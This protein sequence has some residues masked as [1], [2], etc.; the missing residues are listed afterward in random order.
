MSARPLPE[1]LEHAFP[2]RFELL[3][4]HRGGESSTLQVRDRS[5][6]GAVRA[7][8]ILPTGEPTGEVGA[9]IAVRHPAVAAVL[10]VGTLRNG[11]SFVLREWV[12]G[13]TPRVLPGDPEALKALL[14]ELLEVLAFVH[15]RG[16]LHLDLKPANLILRPGTASSPFRLAV[17][18][19]GLAVRRGEDSRGGTPFYAAP[20]VLLGARPDERADLFAVGAIAAQALLAP[21]RLDLARFVAAFPGQPFERAAGF[22]LAALPPPFGDF[23]A[24]CVAR[25]PEQRFPDAQSALE[26]LLGHGGR[27]SRA[28]LHLDPVTACGT[29]LPAFTD[30][31]GDLVLTGGSPRQ[32][33]GLGLH[34]A[35]ALGDVRA[36]VEHADQFVLHRKPG[37]PAT[38]W[39]VPPPDAS[40]LA[41]HLGR[42]CGLRD[43]AAAQA[44]AWLQ[45]QA[46]A[47]SVDVDAILDELAARGDLVPSGV[48]FAWPD[49]AAGRLG[50]QRTTSAPPE[51][52]A[53]IRDLAAGGRPREAI[54]AFQALAARADPR[55]PAAREALALG[56]LDAGEPALALPF[57]V[58]LDP[59]RAQALLETGNLHA[60]A[61]LVQSCR[62]PGR[63]ASRLARVAAQLHAAAGRFDAALAL[64][65]DDGDWR[66]QATRAAILELAGRHEACEALLTELLGRLPAGQPFAAG[67]LHTLAGHL[68]RRRGDL[69]VAQREFEAALACFQAIG[70]LRHTATSLLNLGVLAKD[71]GEHRQAIDWLRQAQ[72]LFAHVGDAVRGAMARASLGICT[73]ARGDAEQARRDLEAAAR[74][75]LA[76]GERATAGIALAV[77]ARA[78][79]ELGQVDDARRLLDEAGPVIG[80]RMQQE[81]DF[82]RAAIDA[83]ADRTTTKAPA[84]A[85]P[86]DAPEAREP[87]PAV[88][89]PSR[90]LFRA[91]LSVNRQLARATDLDHAL[92]HLLSTAV[93]MTG[94]EH[95]YLLLAHEDGLRRELE[96]GAPATGGSRF[97]RSL[98][99]RSIQEQRVM[100][101]LDALTA[102]DLQDAP[103]VRD[104]RIRAAICAPFRSGQG[105]Q[106]AI[107]VEHGG[108]QEA[109]S[110]GDLETMEVLADQAAIAVD[111]LRREEELARAL[112]QSRRELAVATVS[113]RRMRTRLLG[114]GTAMRALRQEIGRIAA[115]DLPVLIQGETGTGKELVARSLHELSARSRGPFV[116]E[117]F[118]ALS[119]ELCERELFGHVRGAFTGA[120]DDRPGLLELADG[121]TLLLDEVGD[122]PLEQ[123]AKLLRALQDRSIRR[124]G[125]THSQPIDIRVIAATHRDLR[126]MIAAGRFRE[127]LFFRLAGVELRVP[128][129]RERDG[130]VVELAEE[131]LAVHAERHGRRLCFAPTV[132]AALRD[133]AWPGNVRELEHVVARAALLADG[134]RIASIDLPAGHGR[135][136]EPP[137]AG[138][139]PLTLE[140]A[141][142][143]AIVAAL[144][145]CRGDKAKAARTLGISRSTLYEKL[146]RHGLSS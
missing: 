28:L 72:T 24:R 110:A 111:R 13:E 120:E 14:R 71:C 131:F 4:E 56:L 91:F 44:A 29:R 31:P 19:F 60:A 2:G 136:P 133:Y 67:S 66:Q 39:R 138:S 57:S 97:S 105:V 35:V 124:I 113:R 143:R 106:G 46:K 134:E 22:E 96:F 135:D 127:D 118:A 145:H 49:A 98:A 87:R 65:D 81:I 62:D 30:L 27:P 51:E 146:R 18:D 100:T 23:I 32:R 74:A 116:A 50:T 11:R 141:E 64:L 58:G 34:L 42:C 59:L 15:L 5:S 123:Q 142:R 55:E 70:N 99:H 85:M 61:D 126:A 47:R 54:A 82:A 73:L 107:Y 7:L 108:R 122:M 101:G 125:S 37:Q 33:H 88:S 45:Q 26:F 104:L 117:N 102:R 139:A 78:A 63:H 10:E 53:Q 129:L 3:A 25:R 92:H 20:E 17:L 103:S 1:D 52:P 80:N 16:V 128:P 114:S 48:R 83:A 132:L 86:P 41:A 115:L 144:Q 109:F 84:L 75:L 93:T 38:T 77:A 137:A 12:D 8:R 36:V 112:Q 40:A 90:E 68:A 69:A 43:D 76:C 79:A 119:P 9:L 130:D 6:G 140:E 89:W 95:G 94:A 121:G 21:R